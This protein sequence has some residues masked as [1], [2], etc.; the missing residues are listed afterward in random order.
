M[1]IKSFK[2]ENF[3]YIKECE[4]N[5]SN[6]VNLLYGDNAQGKTNAVEGIYIFARGKSHRASE[7][8]ELVRFGADGF[9]I[10]IEYQDK[11]GKNSLEY[12]FFGKERRRKKNG[13][14]VEK[15]KRNAW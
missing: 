12:A 5:F 6:G 8:K 10:S 13:Y 7:E 14:R 2:A 15:N 3:R 1:V 4:I 11:T 9:R